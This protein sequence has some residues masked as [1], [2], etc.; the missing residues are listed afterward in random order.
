MPVSEI[1]KRWADKYIP[2]PLDGCERDALAFIIQSAIDEAIQQD[3]KTLL[4]KCNRCKDTFTVATAKIHGNVARL[5]NKESEDE[6]PT[7]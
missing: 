7:T 6:C 2:A 5:P 3:H 4:L 1:A